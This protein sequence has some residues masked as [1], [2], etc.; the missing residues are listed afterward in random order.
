MYLG[1]H[2]VNAFGSHHLYSSFSF[3]SVKISTYLKI[4]KIGFQ[5]PH[6]LC[7][8]QRC[9]LMIKDAL[10]K[11]IHLFCVTTNNKILLK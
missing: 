7:Q 11:V 1:V 8:R 3:E 4:S 2:F 10:N 5:E 6:I 9:A